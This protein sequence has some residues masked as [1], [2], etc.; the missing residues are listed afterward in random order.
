TAIPVRGFDQNSVGSLPVKQG[1][2]VP[3]WP[4]EQTD[5][6]GAGGNFKLM[7]GRPKQVMDF[8]LPAGGILG[9]REIQQGPAIPVYPVSDDQ[10]TFD[11]LWPFSP[12]SISGL[13][14]WLEAELG[15]TLSDGDPITTWFDQSGNSNDAT[16]GV[17]ARR[18][19]YRENIINTR[20][21]VRFDGTDDY[22]ATAAFSSALTQPNTIIAV[23]NM[24]N[25]E[26][27]DAYFVDGV[28]GGSRHAIL[29]NLV[30]NPDGL[31]AHAGADFQPDVAFPKNSW[32]IHSVLFNGA[33]SEYWL[34]GA[35]QGLGNAGA[36]GLSG[37]RVGISFVTTSPL[38]GD[39][40]AI[41]VY[42]Q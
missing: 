42:D 23:G 7:Q 19:T 41:L 14:V 4:I 38:D 37:L 3:V 15:F 32:H 26:G 35:S 31:Y 18:P 29:S 12:L 5:L 22:L 20:P 36:Q 27:D 10:R 34:D 11:P 25:I 28:V 6:K 13:I 39:I 16:Q 1:A 17:A 40:Y 8:N 2:A 30:R 9:S 21:I 33:A 24:K